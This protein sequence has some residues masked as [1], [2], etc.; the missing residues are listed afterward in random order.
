MFF[1]Y[2]FKQIIYN[3]LIQTNNLKLYFI[4]S[5]IRIVLIISFCQIK[6]IMQYFDKLYVMYWMSLK[7]KRKYFSPNLNLL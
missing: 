5:K 3:F 6:L 2:I 1:M 4:S 7:K